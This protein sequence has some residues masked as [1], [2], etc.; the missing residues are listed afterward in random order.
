MKGDRTRILNFD[1]PS[2]HDLK[3]AGWNSRMRTGMAEGKRR[4]WVDP[5]E[6]RSIADERAIHRDESGTKRIRLDVESTLGFDGG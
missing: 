5:V 4:F 3:R 1:Q 2:P 6:N